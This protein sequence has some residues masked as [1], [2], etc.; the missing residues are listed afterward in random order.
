MARIA[1]PIYDAAF[2]YLMDE[3]RVAKTLIAAVLQINKS[4]ILE[5]TPDRNEITTYKK[6][7]I[8]ACRLDFT[9]RIKTPDGEKSIYIELQKAWSKDEMKRFRQY[10]ASQYTRASN[11]GADNYPLPVMSIYILGEK[12]DHL[13]EAVTLIKRHYEN[14]KGEEINKDNKSWFVECLSHDMVV[15][16]IPKIQ[17]RPNSALDNILTLFDQSK[18]DP[19]D[20]H[21]INYNIS[22]YDINNDELHD[23]MSFMVRR[24]EQ[25]TANEE[26][27]IQMCLEDKIEEIV[28]G[29]RDADE[30]LA[31]QAKMLQE[32]DSQIQ[33]KDS[34]LQE[35]KNEVEKLHQLLKKHG[36]SP[37]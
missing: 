15:I 36:I 3:P 21:I 19:D 20:H 34:Q 2:K 5:L 32:K 37:S 23:D 11:V 4:D 9:V 31:E 7:E 13:S 18:Q 28:N 25:A 29:K 33:E 12:V 14:Q 24:L 10:L 30:K 16:Q 35:Y 1:N 22:D 8:N 6:D 27:I 17:P 26:M